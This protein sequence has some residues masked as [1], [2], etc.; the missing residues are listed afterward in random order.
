LQH[1]QKKEALAIFRLNTRLYPQSGNAFDSLAEACE[2]NGLRE[3]AIANYQQSL[4]L[5]PQNT[6]AIVQL[7]RLGE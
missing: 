1:N 5:N 4:T 7:K 6:N 3:L 2:A